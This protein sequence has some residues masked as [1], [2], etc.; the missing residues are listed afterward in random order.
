MRQTGVLGERVQQD[1]SCTD[2]GT[3]TRAAGPG[4]PI[5]QMTNKAFQGIMLG[6]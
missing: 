4:E 2:E 1:D 3:I 5:R 6:G